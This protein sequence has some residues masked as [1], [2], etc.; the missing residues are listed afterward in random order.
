MNNNDGP[1]DVFFLH[2][3]AVGFD[4][5]DANLGII[6]K[7]DKHLISRIIV[8][9]NQDNQITSSWTALTVENSTQM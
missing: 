7:E 3:L 6:G 1:C 2:P 5:L 4:C 9:G 8:V